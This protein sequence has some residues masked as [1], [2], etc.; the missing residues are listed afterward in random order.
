MI[1]ISKNCAGFV[2]A[3]ASSTTDAMLAIGADSKDAVGLGVNNAGN[4][5]DVEIVFKFSKDD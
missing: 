1:K 5:K 4:I 3:G 2:G